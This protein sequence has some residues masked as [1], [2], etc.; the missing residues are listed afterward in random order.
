MYEFYLNNEKVIYDKD[1]Y[2]IDYIR[3]VKH[4]T[5]VKKG[6]GDDS[7]G[8]CMVLV[9]SKAT[10]SCHI[11]LSQIQNKNI[12]TVEG[13]SEREKQVYTY[14]FKKVGAVQCGYC[15]PAMVISTKALIDEIGMPTKNQIK[16]LYLKIYVDVRDM[17]K[18]KR[19]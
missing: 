5:S 7:C 14:A 11:K 16:K 17:S 12:T 8:S 3:D 10:K 19:Q 13:I 9:D 18:Y 4:I 1:I 6:C 2:L 15:I